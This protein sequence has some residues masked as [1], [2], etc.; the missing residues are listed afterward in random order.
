M[1]VWVLIAIGLAV[2]LGL[3]FA[4]GGRGRASSGSDPFGATPIGGPGGEALARALQSALGDASTTTTTRIEVIDQGRKVIDARDVPA[5]REAVLKALADHGID[6]E[7]TATGGKPGTSPATG[8]GTTAGQG[9]SPIGLLEDLAELH[10]A[11][12]LT[13]AEFETAKRRVLDEL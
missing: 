12:A 1:E 8:S 6:L 5:L 3:A 11:G 4:L 9:S 10:R 7:D 13:D 2:V